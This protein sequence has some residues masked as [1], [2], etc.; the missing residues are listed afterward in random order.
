MRGA[1]DETKKKKSQEFVSGST[2]KNERIAGEEFPVFQSGFLHFSP[3][4]QRAPFALKTR[5]EWRDAQQLARRDSKRPP[6]MRDPAAKK[7]REREKKTRL[8]QNSPRIHTKFTRV[9]SVQPHFDLL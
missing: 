6:G 8:T 9:P 2:T 7:G 4:I 5:C 3:R 1:V